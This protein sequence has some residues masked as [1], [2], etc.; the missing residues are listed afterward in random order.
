MNDTGTDPRSDRLYGL[1]P[2]IYRMR[3]AEQGYPLRALLAVIAEQ[4]N[5]VE[6]DILRLYGNWVIETAEAWAV[7]YVGDLIGYRPVLGSGEAGGQSTAEGRALE[8]VLVPRREVAN[9]IRD[10]RRKG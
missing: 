5:V 9:T 1:L 2:V 4:V 10:R 6:D 7:P 3:D 8:R